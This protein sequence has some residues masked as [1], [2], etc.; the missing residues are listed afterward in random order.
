MR[1]R[2]I[3]A[4]GT[5]ACIVGMDMVRKAGRRLGSSPLT[6]SCAELCAQATPHSRI[7]SSVISATLSNRWTEQG[8]GRQGTLHTRT[9]LCTSRPSRN[10]ASWPIYSTCILDPQPLIIAPSSSF[11]KPAAQC[12]AQWKVSIFLSGTEGAWSTWSGSR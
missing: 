5:D 3:G 9:P 11:H 6:Y 4:E 1:A 8:A 10:T 2:F 12:I 7:S